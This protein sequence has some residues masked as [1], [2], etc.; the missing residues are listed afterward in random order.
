MR[1]WPMPTATASRRQPFSAAFPSISTGIYSFPLERAARIALRTLVEEM[2]K[3][4]LAEVRMIL[5]GDAD[6]ATYQEA[7]DE[8]AG[9]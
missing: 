2:P 9:E 8:V 1:S 4:D 3:H 5:F 7:L 6:Y